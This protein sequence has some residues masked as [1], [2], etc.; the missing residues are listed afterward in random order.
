MIS[1]LEHS[2]RSLSTMYGRL[3]KI[4]QLELLWTQTSHKEAEAVQ[5]TMNKITD[6]SIRF[7]IYTINAN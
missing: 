1:H 3:P 4:G 7:R 6:K 5:S 2:N